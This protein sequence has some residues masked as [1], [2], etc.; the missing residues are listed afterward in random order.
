RWNKVPGICCRPLVTGGTVQCDM[1]ATL[2]IS[3][4]DLVKRC[5]RPRDIR[6][7]TKGR[8][9]VRCRAA[10]EG[11]AEATADRGPKIERGIVLL[12]TTEEH[13]AQQRRH[14][15]DHGK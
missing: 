13:K 5:C 1:G 14:D 10:V 6:W 12:V 7:D 9:W 15:H 11:D 4:A 8:L 2:C 3:G